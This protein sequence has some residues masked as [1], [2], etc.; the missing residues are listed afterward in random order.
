D[1]FKPFN[2]LYGYAAGDNLI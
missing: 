2:D 1:H